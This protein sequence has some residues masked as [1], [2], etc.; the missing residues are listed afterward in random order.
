MGNLT[1]L[2]AKLQPA[3]YQ[4][5]TVTAPGER[6]GKNPAFVESVA[7][8]NVR[9]AVKAVVERSFI[10]EEMVA[11]EKIGIIG[12]MHHLDTGMVDFFDDAAVFNAAD[13]ARLRA[14]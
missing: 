13:I 5:R 11:G 14:S 9:R 12:A 8:I 4:E 3:V 6:H 2:L 10:L 7:Q 1:E